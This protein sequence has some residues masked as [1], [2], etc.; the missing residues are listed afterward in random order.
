MAE[1]PDNAGDLEQ[2][3][4]LIL[5]VGKLSRLEPDQ[6]IY[7]AGFSSTRTLELLFEVEDIF[8]VQIPDD[9]RFPAARTARDIV[10]VIQG[11]RAS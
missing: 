8:S 9:G 1:A 3:I 2:V 11:S 5:K 10:G 6:D 7:V 4:A